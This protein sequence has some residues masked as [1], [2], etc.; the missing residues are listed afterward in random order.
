MSH[1][2]WVSAGAKA[3]LRNKLNILVDFDYAVTGN[4]SYKQMK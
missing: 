3:A 1:T 2:N 4:G